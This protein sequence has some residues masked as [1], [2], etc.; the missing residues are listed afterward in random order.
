MNNILKSKYGKIIA[1]S[2]TAVVVCAMIIAV[3]L[4]MPK[5]DDNKEESKNDILIEETT[6][7]A[8]EKEVADVEEVSHEVVMKSEDSVEKTEEK[9]T[10]KE[11]KPVYNGEFAGKFVVNISSDY[12][13]VRAKN[14]ADS[15]VIGKLYVGAGGKVVKKGKN[16]TKIKSGSVT[17]WVSTEYLVFDEA[18]E[19]KANEVGTLNVTVT[20]DTLRVRE[21][22]GT[23]ADIAGVVG[24]GETF[25]G[26]IE[27]DEWIAITFEGETGYISAEFVTTELTVGKAIS[28]EEEQEAV[29]LEQERIAA[30]KAEAERLEKERQQ[31]MEQAIANSSIVETVQGAK[32]NISEEE[33]YMIAC[34]ITAE[35][36]YE[37]YEGQLAVANIILN[38]YASGR[39][40]SVKEVLY[41]PG[42]FTVVNTDRYARVVAEGPFESSIKATQEAIAGKNNVP[43]FT[44]FVAQW[45]ADYGR[46]TEYTIIGNQ[47]YYR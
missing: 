21:E 1:A 12:L 46:Y 18:A 28:I 14:S 22:A 31:A 25:V 38:R 33:A 35:A 42:Q 16:W 47:V 2:A 44:S 36:G 26:K 24:K 29:R 34:V 6:T 41:A 7:E 9:T 32:Y 17:G 3:C 27:N 19:K 45:A 40:G 15:E 13:N 11:T 8:T 43:G 20:A 5:S 10:E 37:C 39:Y 23:D 4:A 30:E